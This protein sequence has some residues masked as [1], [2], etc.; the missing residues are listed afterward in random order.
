MSTPRL[1]E[2]K[3]EIRVLGL[4]AWSDSSTGTYETVGVLFRGNRWLDGVLRARSS[5]HDVT[6]DVVDMIRNSNH[7]PQI[8]VILLHNELLTDSSQID[9]H[10]L[11]K[12][13]ERPV[14]AMGFEETLQEIQDEGDSTHPAASSA[15]SIGINEET[16]KKVLSASTRTEN[17]PEALR[18]AKLLK[19]SFKRN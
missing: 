19:D 13:T 15:I 1:R 16:A 7:H 14:I 12:K 18:V 4:A 11:S 10:R 8:R 6:E 5:T 3:K 17:Y 2:I 9:S